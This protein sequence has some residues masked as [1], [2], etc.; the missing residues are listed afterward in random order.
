MT[1]TPAAYANPFHRVRVEEVPDAD[2]DHASAE[3]FVG[4][5]SP[6]PLAPP[7]P[8]GEPGLQGV[9][10]TP[11]ALVYVVGLHGGAGTSTLADLIREEAAG[12]SL[13]GDAAL[14]GN[15]IWPI[16]SVPGAPINVIAVAR[17]HYRGLQVAERF[18]LAWA[19][20]ELPGRLLGIVFVDDGPQLAKAQLKAVER[21]GR[22]TPH[23]WRIPWAEAWRLGEPSLKTSSS[24]ARWIIH[25]VRKLAQ[26][27][28]T[29]GKK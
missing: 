9:I 2:V 22:M 21:I 15:K 29:E 25:R 10:V 18:A 6:P 20:G 3:E 27:V 4:P 11:S 24:R 7:V 8:P 5:P 19:A 14:E 13:P 23:G 16:S 28:P 12:L 17:T 26:T 1:D